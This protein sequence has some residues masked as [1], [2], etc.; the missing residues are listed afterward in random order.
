MGFCDADNCILGFWDAVERAREKKNIK[1]FK[2]YFWPFPIYLH[3][4]RLSAG[5]IS[6]ITSFFFFFSTRIVRPTK[7]QVQACTHADVASS[8]AVVAE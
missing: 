4:C 2:L 6:V 3:K 8:E 1:V 7:I 5:R